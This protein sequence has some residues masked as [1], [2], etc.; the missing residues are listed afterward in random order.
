[1]RLGPRGSVYAIDLSI[2]DPSHFLASSV[3]VYTQRFEQAR[4]GQSPG[5]VS[6]PTAS[7]SC[8]ETYLVAQITSSLTGCCSSSVAEHV[9][10]Q[11]SHVLMEQDDTVLAKLIVTMGPCA[12][13]LWHMQPVS[14][15]VSRIGIKETGIATDASTL[16][17]TPPCF[18]VRFPLHIIW[19]SLS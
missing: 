8:S 10:Q 15:E 2:S 18:H 13:G 6:S 17:M 19:L 7:C 16:K 3:I 5:T 4:V 14:L 11:E 9:G 12:E 1:M